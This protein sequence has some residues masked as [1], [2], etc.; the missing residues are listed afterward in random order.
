M[1]LLETTLFHGTSVD[2]SFVQVTEYPSEYT[3]EI[4]GAKSNYIGVVL[5]G[6]ILVK[7][8]SLTGKSFIIRSLSEG[9]IYGD[10]LVFGSHSKA[11]AGTLITKGKTTIAKIYNSDFKRLLLT[12]P[13]ILTN[14]LTI[15]SDK[16]YELNNK[17]KLL[18]QE[19]LRDKILYYLHQERKKQK[20]NVIKLNKTKE[21]LA[22]E[23]D[24][25]RPSLSRELINM[26]NEKIIEY[27]RYTITILQN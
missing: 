10:V 13:T 9:D 26:K 20:T 4:E 7:T 25:Q 21:E 11:Y 3:L 14:F 16:T 22:E 8:Y 27:D 24:V 1:N 5:S 12:H 15:L 23:L 18:S 2:L 6:S 17:N 19:T